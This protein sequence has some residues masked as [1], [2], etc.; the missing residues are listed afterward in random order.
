[1]GHNHFSFTAG[2]MH[3]TSGIPTDSEGLNSGKDPCPV[4]PPP[5]LLDSFTLVQSTGQGS[6]ETSRLGSRHTL[7][8]TSSE[9]GKVLQSAEPL[10]LHR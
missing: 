6:E 2:D 9:L 8:L 7:P 4:F 3:I 1:M 10:L 5:C